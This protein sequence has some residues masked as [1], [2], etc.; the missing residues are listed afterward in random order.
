VRYDETREVHPIVSS[1]S[2]MIASYLNGSLQAAIQ[3][4]TFDIKTFRLISMCI[5]DNELVD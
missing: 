5:S 2:P 3:T 4:A 1:E